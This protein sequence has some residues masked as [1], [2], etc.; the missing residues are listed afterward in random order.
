MN[1][2]T[3]HESFPTT[4]T[5]L[6]ALYKTNSYKNPDFALP[7]RRRLSKTQQTKSNQCKTA[8]PQSSWWLSMKAAKRICTSRKAKSTDKPSCLKIV[9]QAPSLETDLYPADLETM[10][11]RIGFKMMTKFTLMWAPVPVV[12][13]ST[14][15]AKKCLTTMLLIPLISHSQ[16]TLAIKTN[17][18]TLTFYKHSVSMMDSPLESTH[19]II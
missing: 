4:K 7:K 3:F 16:L 5:S 1:H 15:K 6:Q 14:Q 19:S 17:R 8:L 13:C 10:P 18:S 11:M 2:R 12:H 9:V